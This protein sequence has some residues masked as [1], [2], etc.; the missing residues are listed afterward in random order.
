MPEKNTVDQLRNQIKTLAVNYKNIRDNKQKYFTADPNKRW[1]FSEFKA[2]GA[3]VVVDKNALQ[4]DELDYFT[5]YEQIADK[6]ITQRL[7]IYANDT[8]KH[9]PTFKMTGKMLADSALKTYIK[10][11]KD[12][13]KVVPVELALAQLEVECHLGTSTT[14]KANE[15]SPFNVG[16]YNKSDAGFL[17]KVKDA[18][19]GTEMYFDLMAEDYFS[20]KSAEEFMQ[21]APAN[22]V[23]AYYAVTDNGKLHPDYDPRNPKGALGSYIR[24][25]REFA[26]TSGIG[27]P[28]AA[29][30]AD[31]KATGESNEQ[32][33]PTPD[34]GNTTPKDNNGTTPTPQPQ[35]ST[36]LKS[37][38]GVGGENLPEDVKIVKT[39][40][41]KFGYK[42]TP[43][44]P[45]WGDSSTAA[46]KD[47][48]TKH[49]GIQA[50]KG[51]INNGSKTWS[52]LNASPSAPKTTPAPN[53]TPSKDSIPA[54]V[55]PATLKST[56]GGGGE[57][58]PEDVK[59]VKTLLN[60]YGYKLNVATAWS[61][62]DTTALKAF[63]A[64]YVGLPTP[65]GLINNATTTW[66]VL[67]SSTLAKPKETTPN[68][69]KDGTNTAP[70]GKKPS[71][72]TIAEGEN[73]V[74]FANNP[75]R[76][77]EYFDS[78]HYHEFLYGKGDKAK[79]ARENKE[80]FEWCGIFVGWCLAKA[81]L[82]NCDGMGAAAETWIGYGVKL[83]KPALGCIAIVDGGQHV[84]FV[85]NYDP[86]TGIVT[87]F[88]G[89]QG[90]S[91][92]TSTVNGNYPIKKDRLT[93]VAPSGYENK[94]QFWD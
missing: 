22:E 18:G 46:L 13:K 37:T 28:N 45:T 19:E 52:I 11:G 59:V 5:R 77:M 15:K 3:Q 34:N 30:L 75:D 82:K 14:R 84:A 49:V 69:D 92:L 42:L 7:K 64:K 47:F 33:T 9:A 85:Q 80:M 65:K 62:V 71:W 57:N 86:K 20:N 17:D 93:F 91:K 40:L 63:Q 25:V 72:L 31:N 16:V 70:T 61:D 55:A 60:K 35:P 88:G 81:G 56:V 10:Y 8:S 76:V 67:S 41:N 66:K 26:K 51:L 73:G 12:I 83:T 58:L 87:L 38:V 36:T 27:M 89:N 39:L 23:G 50:P 4:P 43:D 74:G 78:V 24:K 2:E 68:K 29:T 53:T 32:P 54:P 94:L 90:K 21:S 6:Y 48:Q 44:N 1:T 79:K